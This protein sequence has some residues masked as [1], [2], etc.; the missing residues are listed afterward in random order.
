[1]QGTIIRY[2][3]ITQSGFISGFD[4]NRYS[5]SLS[6]WKKKERPRVGTVVEFVKRDR[7]A[8]DIVVLSVRLN[9]IK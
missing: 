5:F 2:D 6:E 9:E 4:K 8:V 7:E 3:E 1:M